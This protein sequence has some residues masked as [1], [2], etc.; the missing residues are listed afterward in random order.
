MLNLRGFF[1]HN[2]K[3]NPIKIKINKIIKEIPIVFQHKVEVSI[4]LNYPFKISF[5][6]VFSLK[7]ILSLEKNQFSVP[8]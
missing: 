7:L 6:F 5:L 1:K 8:D 4:N 2:N 3:P